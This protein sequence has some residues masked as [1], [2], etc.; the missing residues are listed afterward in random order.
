MQKTS[1]SIR[2]AKALFH[3]A[4][5]KKLSKE[6]LDDLK[7]ILTALKTEKSLSL[8]I[9]NP[10]I[11]QGVKKTVFDRI[12]NQ[13]V[14]KITMNFILLVIQKGRE[15]YFSDMIYKYESL[16][17]EHKNICVV[18]VIS[19]E[20]LTD[21]LRVR[22]KEKIGSTDTEIQLKETVDSSLLGGIIIKKGDAQYD[23]SIRKKLNNAKRAF[24]L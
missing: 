22:V 14:N 3:L 8:L 10:T 13:K 16:Y 17:N 6:V 7:M 2:Y 1:A 23:A 18:E 21:L 11:S 24:K 15:M 9:T 12:F 4:L 5:E 19:S 20:P